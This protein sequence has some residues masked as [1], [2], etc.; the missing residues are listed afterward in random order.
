[1]KSSS[2]AVLL[3]LSSVQAHRLNQR[4]LTRYEE[5]EGPTKADFG[6]SDHTV[7]YREADINEKSE[8]K[9]GWTN[10]LSWADTGDDDEFVLN[11]K[12]KPLD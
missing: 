9:S 2:F 11:L 10:P 5:S 7:V 3:L 12:F 6:D 4:S 1:M 8:K